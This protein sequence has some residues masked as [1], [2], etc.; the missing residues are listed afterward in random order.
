MEP[1]SYSVSRIFCWSNNTC[2]AAVG[3]DQDV[4]SQGCPAPPSFDTL[5]YDI[6]DSVPPRQ[7]VYGNDLL[8]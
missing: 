6:T 4:K 2:G 7:L 3:P 8:W 5:P 1:P